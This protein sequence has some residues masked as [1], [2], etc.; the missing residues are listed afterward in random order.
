MTDTQ[1]PRFQVFVQER[2]GLP[3]QDAGSVHATDPELAL[4]NARDVFARR[5]ECAAMW[6]LPVEAIFSRTAEEIQLQGIEPAV[7]AS[8][9][10]ETYHVFCKSR[11]AGTQTQIGAVE[12]PSPE[13]A[14]KL[15]LTK[16]SGRTPPFAWW[17]FPV[18]AVTQSDPEDVSSLY[19]PARHKGFRMSTD[20]HT[21][22]VMREVMKK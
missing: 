7:E 13:G 17:V 20:F 19:A 8:I 1:W 4:Q 11:S 10:G 15:A 22:S 9:G 18:S 6:V 2:A 5:P 21:H 12:S 16:F 14:L 3:F